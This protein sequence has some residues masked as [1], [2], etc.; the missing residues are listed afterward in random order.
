MPTLIEATL[1][2]LS[3]S[4]SLLEGTSPNVNIKVPDYLVSHDKQ[5]AHIQKFRKLGIRVSFVRGDAMGSS[6]NLSGPVDAI[7]RW[8]ARHYGSSA[9]AEKKHPN[10]ASKKSS[11]DDSEHE[12]SINFVQHESKVPYHS[13]P[14]SFTGT[15][16][17]A[18][19]FVKKHHK[20]IPYPAAYNTVI[21]KKE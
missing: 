15:K 21:E 12:Y 11:T 18:E 1:D 17:A 7:H 5:V 4:A 10:L 19:E 16:A 2:T 20:K 8:A 14:L 3:R 6:L 13:K 9:E